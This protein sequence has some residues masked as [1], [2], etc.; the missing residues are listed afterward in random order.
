M[1]AIFVYF[2]GIIH[3]RM[4]F[5]K[6]ER[7]G[8]LKM[9]N[10]LEYLNSP[11][12]ITTFLVGVFLFIQIVGELLEFKGKVVPEFIK[13]RKYFKRKKMEIQALS[14]MIVLLDEHN[15]MAKTI[16]DVYRVLNEL[17]KHYSK[18]NIAMRDGWMREVN[19][20]IS[21]SEKI[22]E[23]QDSLMRELSNKLDKNNA[24]TLALLIDNKRNA[25]INFASHVVDDKCMVTREQFKRVFKLYEEY[26]DIIETNGLTNGEV[27]IAYRIITEAYEN[28]LKNHT[29]VEDIRGYDMNL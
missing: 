15:Q 22:R 20:H 24:D 1:V 8:C 12:K 27:D 4:P 2:K 10:Y 13:V 9:L 7:F 28:H 19:E 6:N 5:Y 26:E 16:T 11:I 17:D 3:I 18:D 23:K 14:Q 25:I 21:S 29:F